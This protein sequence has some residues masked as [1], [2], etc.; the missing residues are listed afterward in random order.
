MEEV[1]HLLTSS[2]SSRADLDQDRL[3]VKVA[4]LYYESDLTQARIAQRMR[5]SRQKV[6][7][8]LDSAK[9]KGI[10]RIVVEPL[11]GVHAELEKALEERYGLAEAV[12]VETS[13]YNDQSVVARETGVG[14]ADYLLRV[15]RPKDRL[16]LSWG[17]TLLGMVNGLRRH[18]H[19]ELRG[20]LVIQ[21]L[22]GVVDPSRDTHSSELARRL[23]HFLGGRAMALPAPGVAGN[24]AARNAFLRDAHVAKVL[25]AAR[26]ADIAFVG[27]GAPRQDSI[28]VRE[29]SIVR[30][31]ELEEL[32]ERGAVGD[33]N[34]RY[35]D[36][37]GKPIP[38]DLDDRVVG[39]A[40][41]DFRRIPHVVGIAGGAAKLDAIRGAL[42]GK[43]VNVLI[44]DHVTAQ[45]LLEGDIQPP[46]PRAG[47][48]R[49]GAVKKTPA[50][51]GRQGGKR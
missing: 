41:E 11:Q 38:S 42:E 44:T 6:Q 19:R 37:S 34:L 21:G 29:G 16:V 36:R 30:W 22:G 33:I 46:E 25:E 26:M 27:I 40:L 50:R 23:A 32:K 4:R 8:L 10:V 48:M 17:G 24:R 28:L 31:E 12:I 2:T 7:R 1:G 14:A 15:L 39:L 13:S 43:L 20:V 47:K 49:E 3:L 51:G 35:F 9:E 45:R 5:L 18:P